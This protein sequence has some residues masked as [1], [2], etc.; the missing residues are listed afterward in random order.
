MSRAILKENSELTQECLPVEGPDLV[1]HRL[2]TQLNIITEEDHHATMTFDLLL[3]QQAAVEDAII[4]IANGNVLELSL[5][6]RR[7]TRIDTAQKNAWQ[8]ECLGTLCSL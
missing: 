3:V 4:I 6:L 2:A 8:S 1:H 5:D 7:K